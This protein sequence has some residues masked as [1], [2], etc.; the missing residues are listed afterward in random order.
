MKAYKIGELAKLVNATTR[1]LR[2]YEELNL[3][4][5]IRNESGQRLY[6]EA[7]IRRLNFIDELKSAGFTL[8]EIKA[9]FESWGQKLSGG[10]ASAET[11]TLVEN[12]LSEI[13]EL[14]KRLDRLQAELKGMVNFL[15]S[16]RQC[17]SKPSLNSCQSCD[18]HEESPT[19]PLLLTLLNRG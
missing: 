14:Q 1:T 5:P 4:E 19:D 10:E 7:A 9:L 12:K 16:C 11:M 17:E 18:H 13:S 6:S 3:L 15:H 2:Y 8:F